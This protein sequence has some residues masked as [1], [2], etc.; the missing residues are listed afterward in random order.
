MSIVKKLAD[1]AG[2]SIRSIVVTGLLLGSCFLYAMQEGDLAI[3]AG[4]DW[5][6]YGGNKAGNRYSPLPRSTPAMSRT[7]RSPGYTTHL[8]SPTL[9]IPAV[10]ATGPFSASPSL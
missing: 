7:Y 2:K 9:I 1:W 8:K 10:S 4:R 5:P 6:T 3:D